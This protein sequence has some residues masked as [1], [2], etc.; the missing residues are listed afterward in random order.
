VRIEL[1][2]E[3]NTAFL[4]GFSSGVMHTRPMQELYVLSI[5]DP[6]LGVKAKTY[7]NSRGQKGVICKEFNCREEK[8]KSAYWGMQWDATAGN[9]VGQGE[10]VL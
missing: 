9:T 8:R 3:R 5:H 7:C 4:S 1:P 6:A 10:W 2:F